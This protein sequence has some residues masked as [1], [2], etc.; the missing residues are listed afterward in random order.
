MLA[1]SGAKPFVSVDDQV[2]PATNQIWVACHQ[3]NFLPWLGFFSKIHL[4]ERFVFLND[5]QIQRSRGHFTNRCAILQ[6]SRRIWLT[7]PVQ[8][9][10]RSIQLISDV[11]VSGD[12]WRIS[13]QESIRHA[14]RRAP[15]FQEVF[16]LVEQIMNNDQNR[17]VQFNMDSIERLCHYLEI[18]TEKFH[19]SSSFHV[20]TSASDRLADLTKAVQG[21]GYLSGRGANDYIETEVFRNKG[22]GLA[23]QDFSEMK[24]PQLGNGNF[25][26]GLSVLDSLFMVGRDMTIKLIRKCAIADK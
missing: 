20:T 11:E 21:T 4:S 10:N 12:A 2:K 18:D 8:R 26:P 1:A 3:P 25:E 14:Y 9:A 6:N 7:V 5:V 16:G 15:Y 19:L 23:F 22:I 17:L 24:R 13:I